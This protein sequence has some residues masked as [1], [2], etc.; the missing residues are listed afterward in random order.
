M[1]A[2][3]TLQNCLVTFPIKAGTIRLFG[4]KKSYLTDETLY[5]IT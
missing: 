5:E 4:R 3:V 1:Y 2:Y